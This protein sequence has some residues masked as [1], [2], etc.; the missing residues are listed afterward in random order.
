MGTYRVEEAT[1]GRA[2]CQN[3]ECKDQKVKIQKGELRFGSWVENEKYQSFTWKHWG[4]VTPKQFNNIVESLED[5]GMEAKD[6]DGFE[7][8]S[9]E[10]Q[11]KIV[12][13]IEAGHVDDA[14]WKGDVEMNRPGK[15]GFRVRG[16]AK[17]DSAAN[18][19]AEADEPEEK[20]KQTKSKKRAA[21]ADEDE[22]EAPSAKKNKRGTRAKKAAGAEDD[23]EDEDEAGSE[24]EEKPAPKKTRTTRAS[25]AGKS[26]R[27]ARRTRQKKQAAEDEDGHDGEGQSDEP[28]EEKPKRGGRKRAAK[29]G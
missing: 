8:L 17:K 21:K 26:E 9:E 15:S 2:G 25:A 19:A 23:G 12:K 11:E 14:D 24:E 10:N 5:A 18:A 13:A 16:G 7:E 29:S 27:P 28:V 4:C 20:P 3:K 1:S 6:L 22:G